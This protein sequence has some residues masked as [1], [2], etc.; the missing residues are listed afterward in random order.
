MGIGPILNLEGEYFNLWP[1]GISDAEITL[2][3]RSDSRARLLN[4]GAT[5]LQQQSFGISSENHG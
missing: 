2:A 3:W 4:F 5:N 1:L